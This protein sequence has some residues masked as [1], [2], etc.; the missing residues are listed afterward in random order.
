MVIIRLSI[1]RM[2]GYIVFHLQCAC[3]YF[4]S[5]T[6]YPFIF[7][8]TLYWSIVYGTL[9]RVNDLSEFD[10]ESFDQK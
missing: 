3:K 5:R 9:I 8:G 2:L 10:N 7:S 6:M 1:L 4:G